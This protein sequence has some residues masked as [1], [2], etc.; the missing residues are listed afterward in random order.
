MIDDV[1]FA[2]RTLKNELI[3][4]MFVFY[5]IFKI[6]IKDPLPERSFAR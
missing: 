4:M 3:P 6:R 2:I 5:F 1:K